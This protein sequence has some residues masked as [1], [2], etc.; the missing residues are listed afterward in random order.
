MTMGSYGYQT[1]AMIMMT[2]IIMMVATTII[3]II[4]TMINCVNNK[5]LERK[6]GY[7]QAKKKIEEKGKN[8]ADTPI[9]NGS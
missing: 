8:F 3:I 2:I 5:N 6:N 9:G 1:N 7:Y 4:I